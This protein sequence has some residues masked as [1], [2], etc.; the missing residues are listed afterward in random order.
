MDDDEGHLKEKVDCKSE[1]KMQMLQH[2][3][4]RNAIGA[5]FILHWV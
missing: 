1:M 2:F 5:S 3:E 4:F